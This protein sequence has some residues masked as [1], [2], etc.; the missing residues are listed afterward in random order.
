MV[1]I[2]LFLIIILEFVWIRFDIVH[3]VFTACTLIILK[4]RL[5]C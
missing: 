3:R 2:Y 4:I 5:K 1:F